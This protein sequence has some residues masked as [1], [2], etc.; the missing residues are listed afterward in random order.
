[1][2]FH[3][4]IAVVLVAGCV[5]ACKVRSLETSSDL[6]FAIGDARYSL[7]KDIE[8]KNGKIPVCLALIGFPAE[9]RND[10]ETRFKDMLSRA[11]NSWNSLLK[12]HPDWPLRRDIE[13][14]FTV[15]E[16][17]CPTSQSGF[18]ARIWR[19]SGD[20]RRDYCSRPGYVCTSGASAITRF[21]NIGPENRGNPSDIYN[22]FTIV[23]E[24][25]HLLGLGD[26][27]RNKGLSDWD[28]DQPP[29]V[30]NGQNFPPEVFTTDDRWGVWATLNALKSGRRDCRGYGKEVEMK[31]NTW[32]NVMCDPR[33]EATYV[34]RSIT[35]IPELPEN[36]ETREE[37]T[38]VATSPAETGNWRYAGFDPDKTWMAVSRIEGKKDSFRAIG[39]VN[40]ESKSDKGTVYECQPALDVPFPRDCV[41]T[42]DENYKI[43]L[44]G[45]RRL[46]LKTPSTPDGIELTWLK[47]A[48]EWKL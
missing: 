26:T 33:A 48:F 41:A 28:V 1:M 25:G 10:A 43:V 21:L 45:R 47:S 36:R 24:Y 29:S 31:L 23:H 8:E 42:V 15:Q 7:L 27:Y 6:R 17:E 32:Q 19:N 2:T 20:F 4:M 18:S 46:I 40:G 44:M 12:G 39:F 16:T 5:F 38:S 3:R 35:E 9:E 34:H 11:A 22:Y 37:V 14:V 30:M 13:L